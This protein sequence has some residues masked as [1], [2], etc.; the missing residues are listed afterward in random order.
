MAS[1][2]HRCGEPGG[3]RFILNGVEQHFHANMLKD[4]LNEHLKEQQALFFKERGVNREDRGA[5][6]CAVS[7][8]SGGHHSKGGGQSK[9]DQ[10]SGWSR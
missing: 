8:I 2:C 7:R 10:R 5:K 1:I 9:T 4:C 3:E 6:F